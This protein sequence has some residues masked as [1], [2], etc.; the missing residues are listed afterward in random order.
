M[1]HDEHHVKLWAAAEKIMGQNKKLYHRSPFEYY[2][3]YNYITETLFNTAH[4][5]SNYM[6]ILNIV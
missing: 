2:C 4:S 1:S 6:L 3:V 5:E